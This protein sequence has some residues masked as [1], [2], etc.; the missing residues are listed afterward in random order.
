LDTGAAIELGGGSAEEVQARTQRFLKTLTQ[1]S[2]RYGRN[3]EALETADLRHENGYALRLRGV[4]TSVLD[5][6]KK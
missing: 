2:S 6:Q 1:V 3:P 4:T 5:E